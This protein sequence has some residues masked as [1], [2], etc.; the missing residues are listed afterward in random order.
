MK[1]LYLVFIIFAVLYLSQSEFTKIVHSTDPEAKCLDGSSPMLY[2]HEGGDTKNIIFHMFGGAACL[3]S[4]LAS[5][6]E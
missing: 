2:L 6:L 5:T 1:T 3:G 4:D